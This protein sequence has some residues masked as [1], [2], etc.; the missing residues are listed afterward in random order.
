MHHSGRRESPI[1][2]MGVFVV[3]FKGKKFGFVEL[4]LL[5]PKMTAGRVVTVP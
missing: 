1:K 5:K 3:P 2:M 4:R